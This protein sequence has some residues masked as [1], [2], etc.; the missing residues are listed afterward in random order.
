MPLAV[1]ETLVVFDWFFA[2]RRAEDSEF[3]ERSLAAS[4]R[5]QE[6]DIAICE[7]VQSGLASPAYD[8]GRYAPRLETGEL[9]FRRLLAGDL[10][11]AA[12]ITAPVPR[13]GDSASGESAP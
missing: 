12:G 13:S 10:R 9:H 4:Q 5:V 7:S 11:R 8:R 1:D 2:P 3:V 6:E